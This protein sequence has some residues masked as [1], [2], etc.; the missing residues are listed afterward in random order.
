[1]SSG[2]EEPRKEPDPLDLAYEQLEAIRAAAQPT[3]ATSSR[4]GTA[5]P[6]PALT[7]QGGQLRELFRRARQATSILDLHRLLKTL[8][9]VFVEMTSAERG[10]IMLDWQSERVE[11]GRDFSDETLQGNRLAM[12]RTVLQD[13]ARTG[14][15]VFVEDALTQQAYGS[16]ESIVALHL[17]SFYCVPMV[18]DGQVVGICYTDSRKPGPVLTAADRELMEEFAAQAAVSIVNARKHE[19]LRNDKDRLEREN[20]DLREQMADRLG[21]DQL[22]GESDRMRDVIRT[23]KRIESSSATVLIQGETGT[24]KELIARAIH[25]HSLRGQEVLVSVN[26]GAIPGSLVESELFG[27]V[28]GAFTDA[29]SDRI[30]RITSAHRGTLFLDEVGEL[31]PDIQVKLLR[32]LQEGEL[33][34]VG[35]DAPVSVDIRVIAATNRDLETEVEKGA[36]REDLFYRLHV[37]PLHVPPLR[38]RGTDVLLLAEA[39]LERFATEAGKQIGGFDDAARRWMLQF[40]WPGNVRQLQNAI[41]RA[42]VLAEAGQRIPV[43]LFTDFT[44][45]GKRETSTRGGTL[46]EVLDAIESDEVQ[47]ALAEAEGVVSQAARR[48][49]VS[50]QHLHNLIRKHGLKGRSSR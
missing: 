44:R 11:V 15:S 43:H 20:R 13:V 45:D 10:F 24:G 33:V 47:R 49:G 5:H 40:A 29:R 31:P 12:S 48:L 19:A 4:S 3:S 17:R 46:R 36:F 16:R 50:R 27:Y 22:I 42:V 28:R 1:M 23:L 18:H 14:T 38:E 7:P 21:Y 25:A 30:G 6:D 8:L 2:S 32:V 9:D 39:F 26:C 35:S 37:I 34:P 41:Q